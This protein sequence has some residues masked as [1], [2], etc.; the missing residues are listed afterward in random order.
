MYQEH[1]GLQESPFRGSLDPKAFFPSPTHEEALARLR[2]LV[3][4]RHRLGLLIGPNGSGKSLLLEILAGQLR[5]KASSVAKVSLLDVEPTEMLA[6][7][8]DEWKLTVAW[9][10]SPARLWREITDRLIQNRYQQIET[11]VLLDDVDQAGERTWQHINRLA[12]FEQTRDMRL[13]I[14]LAG[15]NEGMMRLGCSLLG[16][17]ELR[18]E[19]EPWQPADTQQYV[20][21]LLSEADRQ[22]P[23]FAH[24]A[25][26][27]LHELAGGIPRRVTQLADLA[28]LAGAGQSLDQIDA[29]V[30]EAAY[31]ELGV[32][33]VS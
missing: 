2:F 25:V 22:K 18:V 9:Q 19:L 33:G 15:R 1:W 10:H 14:V 11:V 30:V 13:T 20:E 5:R 12:R 21:S 6:M 26:D 7:L 23:I 24:R 3:E 8:A 4:E 29:G 17:A 16:L 31:Q 28:L 27:R 32:V